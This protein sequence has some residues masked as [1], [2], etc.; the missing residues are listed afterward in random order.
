MK[1]YDGQT[2]T[3]DDL[4]GNESGS[5]FSNCTFNIKDE[6]QETEEHIENVNFSFA[7]FTGCTWNAEVRKCNL[8]GA[9]GNSLPETM[10]GCNENTGSGDWGNRT[11]FLAAI[12][13][14]L[15]ITT[16][17]TDS[18]DPIDGIPDIAADGSS[19]CTLTIKKK[20]GQTGDYMTEAGDND[21]VD[22]SATRGKLS[23]LR[24]DLVNGE[25]AVTLTSVIESVVTD[26][27]VTSS[28]LAD[29]SIQIQF[30]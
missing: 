4:D 30:A 23:A 29:D 26:V 22:I 19:T 3:I 6:G 5:S 11:A 8:T 25:A 16:D 28:G 20:N 17:A 18:L 27:T 21:T 9:E 15:E 12:P 1:T 2:L 10:V 7:N 13:N 24:V 14:Q